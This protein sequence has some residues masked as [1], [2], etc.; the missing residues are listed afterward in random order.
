M[1]DNLGTND[2]LERAAHAYKEGDLVLAMHLYLAAYEQAVALDPGIASSAA[3]TS[4]REAW[5]LACELKERSMAE[6]VFEKI[7]PFLSGEEIAHYANKLQS[8]A[9]DR[10]EEYGFSREELQDMADMISQDFIDSEGS[11]FK[12]ESISI[13]RVMAASPVGEATLSEEAGATPYGE[14]GQ[15]VTSSA[16]SEFEP[17]DDSVSEQTAA[18]R[19]RGKPEEVGMGV[20]APVDFNPYDMYDTSSV[21]KSYHSA[22]SDGSGAYVF[23]RDVDR[24]STLTHGVLVEESAE[25]DTQVPQSEQPS[26]MGEQPPATDAQPP[27]AGEQPSAVSEQPQSEQP[28]AANGENVG[29]RSPIIP[30]PGVSMRE[31]REELPSLPE[32]PA[33][34]TS[35]SGYRTLAGYHEAVSAMRDLGIGLQRDAGFLNFVKM[36]NARHGLDRMPALDTLLFRSP[37]VE[38]ATRFVDATI[39]EIGL[40]VVRMSMEEGMQGS[41]MLCVTMQGNSRPK[42]NHANNRFDGPGILVL[43]DLDMWV[44]PQIPENVEGIAGFMMANISRGAR[45]AMNLIRS[46]VEDPDVFVL[47][48]ASTQGEVD[49]F[50]YDMLE[51]ISIVD[52]A[53]PTE[54]E[55]E[56]IWREIMRNHPSMRTLDMKTLLRY[57]AGLAR[58]DIYMAARAAIEEAYKLGLAQ[59]RYLPV[60]EQNIFDKL[61]NCQPLD[62]DE[63]KAIEDAIVDGFREELDDLEGLFG[64]SP[65]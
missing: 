44:M 6:Y 30:K 48:T 38:D 10:L 60:A 49:P 8:L 57:S 33:V 64:A 32:I 53:Y 50:F 41:P 1:T 54:S 25:E 39:D 31:A 15:V 4:L 5:N 62:S 59:H 7:E 3:L 55:R 13:P 14:S 18:A 43:D 9:L 19:K 46:A 21:G 42:M 61:A 47:A 29:P 16:D 26:A 11:I 56:D 24:E 28:S 22:T 65:E 63:Y 20:A 23:T 51:P 17:A 35:H 40:P 37:I 52:I 2:Y 45:E 12:V 58:F 36:M 34:S 27:A